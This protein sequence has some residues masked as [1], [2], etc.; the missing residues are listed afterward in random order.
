MNTK[1]QQFIHRPLTFGSLAAGAL[2]V[3]A[4]I[5]SLLLAPAADQPPNVPY[6][7][8]V[9]TGRL[10]V[11]EGSAVGFKILTIIDEGDYVTLLGRN[12]DES[13]AR[14]R[15][16]KGTLGWVSTRYIESN[17]KYAVLSVPLDAV[18]EPYAWVDTG[19]LN[20]RAGPGPEY[21]VIAVL[22]QYE[23]ISLM[24]RNRNG[25]WLLVRYQTSTI[26][27]A[28]AAHVGREI[29][30]TADLPESDYIVPT[31]PSGTPTPTK[32]P[33]PTATP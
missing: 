12:Q 3:L 9:D 2:V 10:N 33:T 31:G 26:G 7:A 27:W 23:L 20:L 15:T 21:R 18:V 29:P 5:G 32:T 13:W 1:I 24:A 22:D 30:S 11:R 17:V 14:V 8:I 25:H 4:W 19:Q 28:N 16:E 6:W